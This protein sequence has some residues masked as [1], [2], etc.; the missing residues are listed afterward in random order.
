M[1][2]WGSGASWGYGKR[3]CEDALRLDIRKIKRRDCLNPG[4]QFSWQ[5]TFRDSKSSIGIKVHDQHVVL[6]Y[7]HKKEPVE[8]QI[9]LDW[10]S[11]HCGGKRSWWRCPHCGRRCAVLYSA[12][13]YFSCRACQGLVYTSTCET[14]RDRK[15]RRANELRQKIGAKLGSLNRL[16]MF[17]PKGMH[18]NTWDRIML[19]IRTLEHQGFMDIDRMMGLNI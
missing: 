2:G 7:I 16:P 5:W 15:F 9:P 17:K 14:A 18:Q 19:E 8:Q 12:G 1:G 4:N 10:T 13:K 11:C 6:N 3:I